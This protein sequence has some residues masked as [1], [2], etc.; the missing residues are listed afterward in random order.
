MNYIFRSITGIFSHALPQRIANDRSSLNDIEKNNSNIRDD[1]IIDL[2]I[3]SGHAG[4]LV[5]CDNVI[6][7]NHTAYKSL[8][9]GESENIIASYS[10]IESNGAEIPQTA[11]FTVIGTHDVP[12]ITRTL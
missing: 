10:L 7:L 2:K 1:I 6:T 12:I 8:G 9:A 3:S 5:L 4:A 11:C